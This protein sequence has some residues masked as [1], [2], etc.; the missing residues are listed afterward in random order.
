[1]TLTESLRYRTSRGSR[2]PAVA[3]PFAC[4]QPLVRA[5]AVA[6]LAAA[7]ACDRTAANKTRMTDRER[8]LIA[9]WLERGATAR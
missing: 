6:A 5:W 9:R 3:F 2:L 7:L 1:M 8:A 4:W